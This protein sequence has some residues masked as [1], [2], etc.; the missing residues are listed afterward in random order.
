MSGTVHLYYLSKKGQLQI[1]QV[2]HSINVISIIYTFV[3]LD[4]KQS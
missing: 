3:K 2:L 1:L 4:G